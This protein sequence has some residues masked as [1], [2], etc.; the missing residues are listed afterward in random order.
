MPILTFLNLRRSARSLRSWQSLPW[1][2]KKSGN[3]ISRRREWLT[4]SSQ[5]TSRRARRA[6]N[7]WRMCELGMERRT[8]GLTAKSAIRKI[9]SLDCVERRIAL[10]SRVNNRAAKPFHIPETLY[11]ELSSQRDLGLCKRSV[12]SIRFPGSFQ[13]GSA[14]I[15]LPRGAK[16]SAA[17]LEAS[18]LVSKEKISIPIVKSI[19]KPTPGG[20]T[21][22][23]VGENSKPEDYE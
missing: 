16:I 10:S 17:S 5:T 12:V 8:K 11:W 22:I 18:D 2:G 23:L 6:V 3:L 7:H 14:G 1:H 20:W 15:A 19:K 9:I 13:L 21:A 4:S